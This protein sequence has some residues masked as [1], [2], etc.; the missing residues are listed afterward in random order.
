M[1]FTQLLLVYLGRNRA[2]ECTNI[3]PGT[4]RGWQGRIRGRL[5][6]RATCLGC[7]EKAISSIAYYLVSAGTDDAATVAE[8]ET[9]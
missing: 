9:D 7:L 6:L 1:T 2:G 4:S 8:I 5:K 3:E